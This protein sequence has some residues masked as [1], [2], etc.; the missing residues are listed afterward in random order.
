MMVSVVGSGWLKQLKTASGCG[1]HFLTSAF[2]QQ[3][4]SALLTKTYRQ[5]PGIVLISSITPQITFDPGE[6]PDAIAGLFSRGALCDRI[7]PR[8]HW[9]IQLPHP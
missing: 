6:I 8:C 9:P 3:P 7:Y 2:C 1:D 5:K 4:C